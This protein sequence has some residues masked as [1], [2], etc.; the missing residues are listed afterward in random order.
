M[1]IR[2]VNDHDAIEV[3]GNVAYNNK[4]ENF[5]TLDKMPRVVIQLTDD[6]KLY[7]GDEVVLL[8]ASGKE[9]KDNIQ[10]NFE[11]YD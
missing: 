5:N 11:R 1:E 3:E 10:W 2:S 7:K 6:A 8:T 9:A 4:D